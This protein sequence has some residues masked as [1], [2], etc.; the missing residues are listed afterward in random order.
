M[1]FDDLRGGEREPS[2]DRPR[3][4]YEDDREYERPRLRLRESS[5][6]LRIGE[7]DCERG[8]RERGVAERPR[9]D[10]ERD[11]GE[12]ALDGQSESLHVNTSSRP[13]K[14]STVWSNF[15]VARSLVFDWFC[16]YDVISV[17]KFVVT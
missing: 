11:G 8:V 6:R 12:R 1:I 2:G 9:G 13:L 14:L 5:R 15:Q 10:S 17:N 3:A 4:E 16:F 7:R